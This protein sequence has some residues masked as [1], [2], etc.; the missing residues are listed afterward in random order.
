MGL[1][2]QFEHLIKSEADQRAKTENSYRDYRN[3]GI[4]T[5]TIF[6]GLITGAAYK[7]FE[8]RIHSSELKLAFAI[9]TGLV[10]ISIFSYQVI[11]YFGF[12]CVA[13]GHYY[14]LKWIH[15]L[16]NGQDGT[17][18]MQKAISFHNDS[19]IHFW[20]ADKLFVVICFAIFAHL[21]I[22]GLI[23]MNVQNM[24][25]LSVAFFLPVTAGYCKSQRLRT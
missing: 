25:L 4:A 10:V 23:Y 3:S 21:L 22:S 24:Y 5:S 15:S 11:L 8:T 17:L 16:I 13:H 2:E 19:N 9:A 20:H 6:L 18:D 1:N 7:L 14:N 12:R